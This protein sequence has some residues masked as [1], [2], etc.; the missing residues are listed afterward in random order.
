MEY[1]NLHCP[2]CNNAFDKDSDIVVCPECGAPH[3]RECYEAEMHCHFHDKHKDGFDF[4]KDFEEKSKTENTNTLIC[5]MCGAENEHGS[6]F[7][8]QCG[9]ATEEFASYDRHAE[10]AHASK[11]A[12]YS[13]PPNGSSP[14]HTMPNPDPYTTFAFDPMG[15]LKAEEEIGEGVTVGECA[16]FVK[17]NTPFYSRL[18]HQMHKTGRGRFSFSGFLFSGLWLMYRKMYKIGTVI[19]IALAVLLISQIYIGTFYSDLM[20]QYNE[21]INSTSVFYASESSITM[22]E[23]LAGLDSEDMIVL[24]VYSFANSGLLAL[25]VIC[26]IFGN[27][28][29]KKHCITK[30][31]QIK[32]N[33]DSKEAASAELQTKGGVNLA[34]AISLVVTYFLLSALSIFF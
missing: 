22:Q 29:Y 6:K 3:H 24:T 15:G 18:F 1:N 8:N 7:C 32:T 30:I 2:V 27:R 25:R 17:N 33:A 19:T 10:E 4:K 28:W 20:S 34:L 21:A 12:P 11:G 16:K 5:R 14:N 31:K 9:A 26:G 23:F 13:P